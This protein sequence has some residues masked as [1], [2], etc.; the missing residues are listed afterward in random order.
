MKSA[1]ITGAS[2]GIGKGIAEVFARNGYNIAIGYLQSADLAKET[3][4]ELINEYDIDS[5]AI[6]GDVSILNDCKEIVNEVVN[7]FG[8]IDILVNNAAQYR[9]YPE[10]KERAGLAL[11]KL[12]SVEFLSQIAHER[13][14][15]SI[16]NISSMYTVNNRNAL[17]ATSYQAGVE[18]MTYNFAKNYRGKVRVNGVRPGACA[19]DMLLENHSDEEIEKFLSAVPD[20][21]LID[22]I[23]MG[24]V[25]YFIATNN[26]LTG[27]IITAD[28]GITLCGE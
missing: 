11:T 28:K 27:Q 9:R 13:G 23:E 1:L 3:C 16:V 24:T 20:Q 6:H 17:F 10:E 19:T 18:S 12:N 7:R 15:E 26:L 21:E 2:R 4:D 22:P 14:V 25:V 8:S 5:I